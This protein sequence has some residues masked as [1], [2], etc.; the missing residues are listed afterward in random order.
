MNVRASV[1]AKCAS[2]KEQVNC[3]VDQATDP[4]IL[5]RSWGNFLQLSTF[6]LR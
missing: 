3:L 5:G 1:G 4:N 6:F 2:V